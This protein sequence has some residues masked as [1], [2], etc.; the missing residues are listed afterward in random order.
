MMKVIIDYI[1]EMIR[2]LNYI[3]DKT[4]K[5]KVCLLIITSLIAAVFEMLGVTAIIPV[6]QAILE[7]H[8]LYTNKIIAVFV[9]ILDIETDFA[10]VVLVSCMLIALYLVKNIVLAIHVYLTTA[11]QYYGQKRM[12]NYIFQVYMRKPYVYYLEANSSRIIRSISGDVSGVFNI[13]TSLINIFTLFFTII[14]IA[15][16]IINLDAVIAGLVIA[17]ALITFLGVILNLKKLMSRLGEKQRYYDRLK[18]HSA[19]QAIMGVKE[20]YVMRRQKNFLKKYYD[21][22][23]QKAHIDVKYVFINSCPDKLIEVICVG[24]IM[25]ALCIRLKIGVN[26]AEFITNLA[27]FA[28][29][30]F[31]MMPAIAKLIGYVN[32][33]FFYRKALDATYDV[34]YETKVYKKEEV[35]NNVGYAETNRQFVSNIC[36]K[37]IYWKYQS[38]PR[39]I[40]EDLN[41]RIEKGSSVAFIGT[42]GSGKTTLA[43]IILGLLRP[44][45]GC[46]E[47]D[48]ISIDKIPNE[49][50]R[51]IGYVPQSVFL[52]DDTITRN[53]L[54]GLPDEEENEERVW[55]AL[56]QAQLAEFVREL[57]EGLNTIVGERGVKFSGGQRQRIAIARTLY[58]NPE[59]I[60][61]DEATAALDN[62]TEK[63]VMEAIENLKG[64]KTLIIIAH[65]LSTIKQCDVIYEVVGGK[66][67]VRKKEEIFSEQ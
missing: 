61:L 7:P 6:V 50:S 48:G 62:D 9:K 8:Q 49:W 66:A 56:E 15:I 2:K 32:G 28:V 16:Y 35:L 42:S 51:M 29:A 44:E 54:F 40:L 63:A 4:E 43:D 41:L 14:F 24:G 53:I 37:N 30:A 23:E 11:F 5:K 1:F 60:L 25:F 67:V 10:L 58:Y 22:S 19:Y 57:P 20:V 55:E 13:L 3:L 26:V 39:Y 12:S 64:K 17:L 27:A 31:R 36:L 52:M 38:N 21:A 47:V 59:I 46:V 34:I 18:V 33:L 65:R 45:K